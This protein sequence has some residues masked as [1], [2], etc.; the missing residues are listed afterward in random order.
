MSRARA[1]L[2]ALWMGWI[3]LLGLAGLPRPSAALDLPEALSQVAS[4]NPTLVAR[5]AMVEAARRR[6]APATAWISPRVELGVAN[7][8]IHGGLDSDPMTMKMIEVSQRLPLFGDQGASRDAAR[9][10]AARESA[11]ATLAAYDLFAMTWEAYAEARLAGELAG[12]AEA[13]IALMHRLVES[14]RARFE[15]GS[16][17][18]EDLLRS[19]VER[20]STQG[21]LVTFR[22]ESQGARARLDALRGVAPGGAPGAAADTLAPMPAPAATPADAWL[23]TLGPDHPRLR[24]LAAEANGYRHSARAT[25]RE[26]WPDLEVRASYGFRAPLVTAHAATPQEDMFSAWV[27]FS[28]PF[29]AGRDAGAEGAAMEAMARASEAERR[30]AELELRRQ[31]VAAHIEM[32]AQGRTTALLADTVITT[33]HR[34]VEASWTAYRAGSTDLWRVF[35]SAHALYSNELALARARQARARAEARL[36]A[37]TGRMDL[38]G[39]APPAFG[40]ER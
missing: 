23:T 39:V 31:V 21:D 25:R 18:L 6:V 30:G 17:R 27:G 15:S 38:L 19:Q 8:P 32:T 11:S 26:A 4:A 20:S 37:L 33:L 36:I 10:A 28:L 29:L 3:G 22:A 9:E 35:E 14:A 24:G 13:H 2:A 34:A 7:V 1:A 16:G 40:S 12:V 5:G